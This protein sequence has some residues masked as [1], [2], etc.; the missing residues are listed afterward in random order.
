MFLFL[1]QRTID[2]RDLLD[3]KLIE[4]KI[5]IVNGFL[6]INFLIRFQ[7]SNEECTTFKSN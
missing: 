5:I 3:E 2:L 1:K 6:E 4:G 7:N